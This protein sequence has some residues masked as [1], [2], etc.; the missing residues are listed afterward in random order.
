MTEVLGFVGLG[1]IGSRVIPH[2][3]K[4]G[5]DVAVFDLDK[6]AVACLAAQGARAVLSPQKQPKEHQ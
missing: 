4:A 6:D 5:H 1:H 2:L 3:L